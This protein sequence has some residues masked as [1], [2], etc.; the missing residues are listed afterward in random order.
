MSFR[1]KFESRR[2]LSNNSWSLWIWIS[3]QHANY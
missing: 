1:L 2:L 3:K